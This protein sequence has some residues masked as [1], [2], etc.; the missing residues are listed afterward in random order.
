MGYEVFPRTVKPVVPP[1]ISLNSAGRIGIN[2]TAARLLGLD[3][4]TPVLLLWDRELKSFAIQRAEAGDER[5]YKVAYNKSSAGFSAK[6]FLDSIGA[7]YS[8]LRTLPAKWND[9]T[10]WDEVQIQG[11]MLGASVD[12]Q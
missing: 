12:F 8:E 7:D 3:E 2:Q 5:A 11:W 1:A 6:V 9:E 10:K 4:G